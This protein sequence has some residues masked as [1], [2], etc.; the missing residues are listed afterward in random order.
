MEKLLIFLISLFAQGLAAQTAKRLQAVQEQILTA[1]YPR[2][3]D[4]VYGGFLTGF[5]YDFIPTGTQEKFI[6]T[7]ARHTWTNAQAAMLFPHN[8]VY[9]ACAKHGFV[10]LKTV[11]WDSVY[12]GFYNLVSREG[13]VIDRMQTPKDAYGNAF[14]LYAA[15]AYYKAS[16]DTAALNL[17]IATFRWL[18]H[19]SHDAI[20]KGYFQH[21]LRD[22]TPATRTSATPA[23]SDLG[24]KDQNSSIH[25]LEAFTALYEV[26]KDALLRE[27]LTEMQV[28]IRDKLVTPAGYLQLFF[29]P[30]WAPVSLRDSSEA[31]IRKNSYLDH[32]SYGHD[33]ETAY[34]LLEASEALGAARDEKT[35]QVA[36][37]M[38]DHALRNG[39]D[40]TVG[41]FYDEGYYFKNRTGITIIKETK[42]WWAQ[43][44]GLNSLLIMAD[45]FPNDPM[46]YYEKFKQLWKY[47]DTCLIDHQYGDWF[48]EGLDKSPARKTGP[49]GHMWKA[50]YHQFRALSNCI[51]RLEQKK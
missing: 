28:L 45:L 33:V 12:G 32:V 13:K 9:L 49:K 31:F 23:G 14:G 30:A 38:V 29:K 2:A 36:K 3:V 26:W 15:V 8:P 17:A 46:R 51:E 7:Q 48:E 42:N 44:E 6:V 5:T 34:L 40:S 43:A 35:L 47:I 1:W 11:M 39:W 22:G 10:F 24:Y 50:N 41:G 19:H 37:R 21:L 18:E 25:L 4:S 16:G 20:Y 27:R